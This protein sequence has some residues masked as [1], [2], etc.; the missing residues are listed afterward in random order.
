[1][2]T[3][4]SHHKIKCMVSLTRGEGFGRPLLEA[5]VN[6]LPIIASKWSGHLDFLD[7][8]LCKLLSGSYIT[9]TGLGD[10]APVDAKWFDVDLK[11]VSTELVDMVGR[12]DVHKTRA[13][14]LE[15]INSQKYS[16]ESMYTAYD[17]V[18]SKY[19]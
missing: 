10:F 16:I 6:G 19:I 3:L 14:K 1:M 9:A 18:L 15:K 12:Y 17:N 2:S 13:I 4:Y 11:N 7:K 5:S 8:K